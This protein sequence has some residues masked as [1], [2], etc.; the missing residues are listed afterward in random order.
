MFKFQVLCAASDDSQKLPNH[1]PKVAFWC[2]KVN[3]HIDIKTGNW[4][5]DKNGK[6]MCSTTKEQV[7]RS[8]LVRCWS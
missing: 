6:S 2:G 8:D 7:L 4:M 3:Q 5:T 1:E